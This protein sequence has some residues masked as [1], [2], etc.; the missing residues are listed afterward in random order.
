MCLWCKRYCSSPFDLSLCRHL[1]TRIHGPY[2]TKGISAYKKPNKQGTVH[3]EGCVCVCVCVCVSLNY[4]PVYSVP[5]LFEDESKCEILQTC[6]EMG[7]LKPIKLI[8]HR[9]ISWMS[10]R[11]YFKT[12]AHFVEI[13]NSVPQ[14]SLLKHIFW[15]T[16]LLSG[17]AHTHLHG[18]SLW[19]LL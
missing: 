2:P 9:C 16:V 1:I 3:T 10:R 18:P 14:K 12:S 8:L 19:T 11:A 5:N 17:T 6:L 15:E 13:C 4:S 7:N